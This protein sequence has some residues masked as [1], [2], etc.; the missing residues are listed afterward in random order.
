MTKRDIYLD[1][2]KL[3]KERLKFLGKC[4][5]PLYRMDKNS[6]LK[7]EKTSDEDTTL[8]Y[9]EYGL[10]EGVWVSVDPKTY[11]D[12]SDDPLTEVTFLQ[13]VNILGLDDEWKNFLSELKPVEVYYNDL[14]MKF[15]QEKEEVVESSPVQDTSTP[16]NNSI[17]IL[18]DVKLSKIG[19]I[20]IAFD[21]G[22]V[23]E[24]KRMIKGENIDDYKEYEIKTTALVL[25][26][27]AWRKCEQYQDVAEVATGGFVATAY[28]LDDE[29]DD[30]INIELKYVIEQWSTNF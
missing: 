11:G 12:I 19:E 10:K 7:G 14:G 28:Y 30:K 2:N 17:N 13:F 3:T 22:K 4:L 20:L 26:D 18:D 1:L 27:K 23:F 25:L 6:F 8:F 29:D 21:F 16:K 24:Y 15:C 5:S 9:D